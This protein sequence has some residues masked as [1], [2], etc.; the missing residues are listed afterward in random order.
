MEATKVR[1]GY[2]N[3]RGLAQPIRLMLEHM[4]A[5]YTNELYTQGDAPE[6]SRDEWLAKKFTLGLD[7]PNLP[8]LI[9]GDF[10]LTKTAAIL[11]YLANKYDQSL[12]GKNN[13]DQATVEMLWGVV[14]DM[15][16]A[17]T[18]LCYTSGDVEEFKKQV[19]NRLPAILKFIGTKD[20]LV[21]DYITY[22][23]FHLWEAMNLAVHVFGGEEAFFAEFAEAKA[24]HT[25]IA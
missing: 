25:R 9:D 22:V 13:Q 12:L 24:Y 16:G 18:V 20:S 11:R 2:W 7:F 10:N 8:Y 15:K 23:D 1:L 5:P 21:G 3:I 6:F 17:I 19:R 4:G 14:H